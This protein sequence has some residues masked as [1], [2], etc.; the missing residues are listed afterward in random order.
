MLVLLITMFTGAAF[1][2]EAGG[3]T[4]SVTREVGSN[5]HGIQAAGGFST[6]HQVTG[7]IGPGS[8]GN[9]SE[10]VIMP[11]GPVKDTTGEP[12]YPMAWILILLTVSCVAMFF[13]AWRRDNLR[14]SHEE[15]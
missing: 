1:A 11:G 12:G 10:G 13:L 14:E 2:G 3:T 6:G 9:Q 7:G 8:S 4:A 5:S 15:S